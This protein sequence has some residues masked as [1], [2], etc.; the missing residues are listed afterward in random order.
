MIQNTPGITTPT[1]EIK[2]HLQN[3][4][5]LTEKIGGT[6]STIA[7]GY[8]DIKQQTN[9]RSRFKTPSLG[10]GTSTNQI[11]PTTLYQHNNNQSQSKNT[12]PEDFT[13]LQHSRDLRVNYRPHIS[14]Y[15]S[16]SKP[17]LKGNKFQLTSHLS[18]PPV[19]SSSPQHQ[20]PSQPK[21]MSKSSNPKSPRNNKRSS[22]SNRGNNNKHSNRD[23]HQENTMSLEN[24][25]MTLDRLQVDLKR[26]QDDF[27]K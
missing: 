21:L 1:K 15:P 19:K 27:K 16:L 26:I 22:N 13:I 8:K 4:S 9:Q 11:T 20:W 2:E 5:V 7:V 17:L 23:K 3:S 18:H 12:S 24:H 25:L 10:I 6:Y 14:S